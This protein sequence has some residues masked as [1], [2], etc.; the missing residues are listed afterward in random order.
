VVIFLAA[1]IIGLAVVLGA[2]Y[3]YWKMEWKSLPVFMAVVGA[4]ALVTGHPGDILIVGMPFVLGG[5]GGFA[6]KKGKSLTFYLVTAT[7]ILA[8]FAASFFYY[9]LLIEKVNFFE[10]QREAIVKSLDAAQV[11]SDLRMQWLEAYAA[12]KIVVPFAVVANSLVVSAIVFVYIRYFLVRIFGAQKTGGLEYFRIN[13]Y[14]IFVLMAGLA[15]YLL[16]DKADYAPIHIA[17]LNVLLIAALFY[18]IQWLAVVKFLFIRQG[19]P[20]YIIF[21]IFAG[22]LFLGAI[23]IWALL[24]LSV[25]LTGLGALDIWAGF[26]KPSKTKGERK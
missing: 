19:V 20:G 11:P 25:L 13:D 22:L 2:A 7:A 12:S 18:F 3:L 15:V 4:G 17:G 24:F 6:C 9:Y 5:L 21:L 16:F 14:C 26:R 8:V 23:G 10:I 1:T